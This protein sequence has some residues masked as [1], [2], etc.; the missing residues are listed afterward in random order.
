MIVLIGPPGAGKTTVGGTLA[1]RLGWPFV[2]TD[3]LVEV[4][5]GRAIGDIFVADG[6]AAFRE[7]EQA[8]VAQALEGQADQVVA[9]GGGA[10]MLEAN[11]AAL[12]RHTVVYLEVSDATAIRRVGLAGGGRPLL[13]ASPRA[14]WRAQMAQRGP[15]YRR[16]AQV[17]VPVDG[18]TPPQIAARI[19]AAVGESPLE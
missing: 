11:Q 8:A 16:L 12:A 5:S 13:A 2:D 14:A 17:V 3:R 7:L 18:L 9:L 15:V 6:E 19:E 1:R 10:P 4:A